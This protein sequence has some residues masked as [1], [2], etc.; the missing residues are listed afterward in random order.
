MTETPATIFVL[1]AF[2]DRGS[3]NLCYYT[4]REAARKA[5]DRLN[6][7]VIFYKTRKGPPH[8]NID[9]RRQRLSAALREVVTLI[10]GSLDITAGDDTLLDYIRFDVEVLAAP[11]LGAPTAPTFTEQARDV[12]T[13]LQS[14]A[15]EC[16]DAKTWDGP[17]ML[18]AF[19]LSNDEVV[20]FSKSVLSAVSTPA[21]ERSPTSRLLK[22]I[23]A[24]KPAAEKA[25][26]D[27]TG[28]GASFDAQAR[29]WRLYTTPD[30]VEFAS[31]PDDRRGRVDWVLAALREALLDS[32]TIQITRKDAELVR[33]WFGS[34]EDRDKEGYL[35]A[36][37]AQAAVRLYEALGRQPDARLLE[38][39]SGE[40]PEP[41]YGGYVNN[42]GYHLMRLRIL[43]TGTASPEDSV[44]VEELKR[45][46]RRLEHRKPVAEVV[47]AYGDP[48]AFGERE[49]KV[50]A[51]L[52]EI[53]YDTPLYT[54]PP[55]KPTPA[56]I[57]AVAL[58]LARADARRTWM[59]IKDS[60]LYDLIDPDGKGEEA[61][62]QGKVDFFLHDAMKALMAAEEA[63]G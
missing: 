46:N 49:I 3:I 30:N 12:A 29:R 7:L 40:P 45:L 39:A 22:A 52:G 20:A 13:R 16:E 17:T 38:K 15:E 6:E 37:D 61:N 35:N 8:L 54:A 56:A 34:L 1:T 19:P 10:P 4:D 24:R 55:W 32:E 18:P 2:D 53:P 21:V 11:T 43:L 58:A 60:A 42:P 41:V 62:A 59:T 57:R 44:L 28:F 47:S 31:M 26:A 5:M 25:F 27:V 36:E 63:D 23:E 51:D 50:L 14:W 48:E 9:E 33:Q